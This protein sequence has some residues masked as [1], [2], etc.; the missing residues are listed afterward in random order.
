MSLLIKSQC[1]RGFCLKSFPV[2]TEETC[3]SHGRS[4]AVGTLPH[5]CRAVW[6]AWKSC[7]LQTCFRSTVHTQLGLLG[8]FN[9]TGALICTFACWVWLSGGAGAWPA[10]CTPGAWIWG[11]TVVTTCC[12]S[13][14]CWT[15]WA[16]ALVAG[17]IWTCCWPAV[18]WD[19]VTVCG[20]VWTWMWWVG[21][22]KHVHWY[23]FAETKCLVPSIKC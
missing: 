14:F 19:N 6:K 22:R 21:G 9:L 23:G 11:D 17:I 20:W 8:A 16:V 13:S 2:Q 7:I 5:V 1:C 18:V 10:F 4:G 15:T 12:C 3:S